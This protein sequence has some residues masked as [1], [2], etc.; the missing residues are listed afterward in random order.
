MPSFKDSLDAAQIEAVAE[1][2]SAAA[3]R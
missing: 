2:V 1:Y 3:G